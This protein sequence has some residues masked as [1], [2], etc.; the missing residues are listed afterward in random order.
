MLQERL[1]LPVQLAAGDFNTTHT[2]LGKYDRTA[3]A[4]GICPGPLFCLAAGVQKYKGQHSAV[5]CPW[6]AVS[7]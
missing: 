4:P 5:T 1:P 3:R 7:S 6:R 2:L